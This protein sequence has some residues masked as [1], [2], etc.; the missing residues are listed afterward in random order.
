VLYERR[1]LNGAFHF[2]T[3]L[4]FLEEL[5]LPPEL[6]M[7]HSSV[8]PDAPGWAAESISA[9]TQWVPFTFTDGTFLTFNVNSAFTL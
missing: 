4:N 6:A 1:R 7:L 3:R 9:K 2:G 5:V 8:G